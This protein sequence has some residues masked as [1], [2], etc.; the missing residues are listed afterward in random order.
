MNKTIESQKSPIKKEVE[1][2]N[3]VYVVEIDKDGD[4]ILERIRF[5]LPDWGNNISTVCIVRMNTS[6]SNKYVTVEINAQNNT[7]ASRGHGM[8]D[9]WNMSKCYINKK[10][11]QTILQNVQHKL[12]DAEDDT[13]DVQDLFDEICNNL[14]QYE[15]VDLVDLV[16]EV[17][18]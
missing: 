11:V 8:S 16:E 17:E 1:I 2:N 5:M 3:N 4:L 13:P 6:K 7:W 10:E 12:A 14:Q 18:D 15:D 9:A